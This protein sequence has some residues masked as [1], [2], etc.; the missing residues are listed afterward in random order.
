[1]EREWWD[2]R[3]NGG[4]EG[5]MVGCKGEWLYGKGNGGM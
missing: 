1:M 3:K 2:E 5:E 4:I